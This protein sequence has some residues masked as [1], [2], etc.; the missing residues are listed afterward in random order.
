MRTAASA[1]DPGCLR[2]IIEQYV[3]MPGLSLTIAQARRLFG[4]NGDDCARHLDALVQQGFLQ[5]TARGLYVRPV[6]E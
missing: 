4:L 5:R 2:Q 3:A 6:S 1:P